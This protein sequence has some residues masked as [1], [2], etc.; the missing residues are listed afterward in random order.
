M[1]DIDYS[2]VIR[3]TGQANEKY[4]ALLDSIQ[5]LN[6]LPKEIIVVLPK[7]S[8]EPSYQLGWETFYFSQ[9]GMV[10]QRMYGIA[11]CKTKYAL[12]SDDDISFDSD[13][14]TKLYEPIAE[15]LCKFSAGPLYSFLPRKGINSLICTVF[16]SAAPTI[17]HKENYCTILNTTGYSYNRN[18][19]DHVKYYF[20]ESLPW[21]CFFAETASLK[22]IDMESEDWLD[23]H[24]YASFDDT[25]MFYKA[26]LMGLNSIV[27]SDAI[28]NHLDARTSTKG[29]SANVIFSTGFNRFVFWHRF[30][31]KGQNNCVGKLWS[32][33]CFSYNTFW[34]IVMQYI[35]DKSFGV[36]TFIKGHK[37]AKK[38]IN[39]DEYMSLPSVF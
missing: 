14:V 26:H 28:Y 38:Y 3:T 35:S 15:G 21:T 25:T 34:N 29:N 20:A 7:G 18:L 17:F 16:G 37:S 39:S 8:S 2:V 33:I 13:F 31:Y 32:K 22:K 1:D 6:P 4:I 11:M 5:L 23:K 36:S 19:N 10:S 27:V 12:V 9:K 24:G 30:I